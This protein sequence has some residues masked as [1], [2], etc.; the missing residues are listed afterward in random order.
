M[1]SY[2]STVF[3][4]VILGGVLYLLTKPTEEFKAMGKKKSTPSVSTLDEVPKIVEKPV[5]LQTMPDNVN[6]FEGDEEN[7]SQ[8]A[9]LDKA[10]SSP[11]AVDAQPDKV[12]F[13]K[14]NVKN[15][16]SKDF[17][18]ME[19]K[20]EWFDT[21]FSLAKFDINDDALI[22]TQRFSVGINTVGQSLKNASHD[23]RG[24]IPNPK[25]TVSPWNNSTYEPDF[26]LK[27]LC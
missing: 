1:N 17:L 6:K 22:N 15:Y 23:V 8:G 10:F 26:N 4:L 7:D 19:V 9:E 24:T 12:D 11:I 27:P 18:P 16:N 25:F 2:V 13:N 14:N 3:L 21:D 5:L 20:G